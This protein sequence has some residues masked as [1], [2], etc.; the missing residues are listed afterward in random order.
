MNALSR[1]PFSTA[2]LVYSLIESFY[3]KNPA[4]HYSQLTREYVLQLLTVVIVL[5][6]LLSKETKKPSSHSKQVSGPEYT[7]Q[8]VIP[9]AVTASQVLPLM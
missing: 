5:Q 2:F 9:G 3:K 1:F 4:A 7:L 8:L 6:V